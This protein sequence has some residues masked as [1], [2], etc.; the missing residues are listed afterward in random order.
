[1]KGL[2]PLPA[3]LFLLDLIQSRLRGPLLDALM[4]P[5]T[6]LG[7]GAVLWIAWSALLLL[8]PRGR[9]AGA[10]MAAGLLLEAVCCNAVLKPLVAR[11]RPYD[12]NTAVQL[13]IRPLT[14]FSFPSGHA[15]AAFAAASAL[16]LS[17]R[18]RR[19]FWVP[20]RLL[21]CALA[22][23]ISFSRLYLYVHYPTDVLA[24]AALGIAAGWCGCRIAD[25]IFFF[26]DKRQRLHYITRKARTRHGGI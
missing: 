24:G 15:G 3:E 20:A 10:A 19:G 17:T 13:L 25:R 23:L 18:N 1:M 21:A 16:C 22:L 7:N 2:N 6:A 14:D 4:P 9:R 5:V 12:V 11:V 26:L 8:L